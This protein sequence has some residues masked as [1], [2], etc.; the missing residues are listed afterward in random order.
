MN[1]LYKVWRLVK[2][3]RQGGMELLSTSRPEESLRDLGNGKK[4]GA[5]KGDAGCGKENEQANDMPIVL[6]RAR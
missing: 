6:A 2:L 1:K 5:A 3:A 4:L